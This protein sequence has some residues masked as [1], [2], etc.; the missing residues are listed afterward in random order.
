MPEITNSVLD[1][2]KKLHGLDPQIYTDPAF[3]SDL[4]VHINMAL[5]VLTQLGAGPA[6]GFFISGSADTWADL[7]VTEANL[8]LIREFVFLKTKIVFDIAGSSSAV[9]AQI[10]KS[11]K[12]L[13]WRIEVQFDSGGGFT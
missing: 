7:G 13:E 6:S 8:N 5:G 11:I 4:I 3:D 10:E 1:T 2:I 9:I 12:E